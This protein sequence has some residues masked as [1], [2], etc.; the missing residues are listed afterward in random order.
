MR[1]TAP[2]P[3]D[4]TNVHIDAYDLAQCFISNTDSSQLLSVAWGNVKNIDLI[5]YFSSVYA[6]EILKD[7][8]IP[9]IGATQKDEKGNFTE[10]REHLVIRGP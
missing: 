6:C 9:R 2:M 5:E 4:A 8:R 3:L 10:R 1:L 7:A